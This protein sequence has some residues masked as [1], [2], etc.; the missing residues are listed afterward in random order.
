MQKRLRHHAPSARH[1]SVDQPDERAQ[2]P[3]LVAAP[4]THSPRFTTRRL[5]VPTGGKEKEP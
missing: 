3:A 4:A 1:I 5:L 2:N